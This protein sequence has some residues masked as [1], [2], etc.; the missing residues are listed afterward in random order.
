MVLKVRGQ[1]VDVLFAVNMGI[2][3]DFSEFELLDT[4]GKF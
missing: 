3:I 2:L 4:F 1:S